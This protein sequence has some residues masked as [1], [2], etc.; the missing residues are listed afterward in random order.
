MVDRIAGENEGGE[1]RILQKDESLELWERKHDLMQV[2][3][4]PHY[5]FFQ[6]TLVILFGSDEEQISFNLKDGDNKIK[7]L[8]ELQEKLKQ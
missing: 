2:Y 7:A 5:I 4:I 8:E 1:M 6:K 3:T